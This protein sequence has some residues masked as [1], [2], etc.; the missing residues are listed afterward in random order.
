MRLLGW[1]PNTNHLL[2]G[3]SL[4]ENI[5]FVVG[6]GGKSKRSESK[7]FKTLTWTDRGMLWQR[8]EVGLGKWQSYGTQLWIC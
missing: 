5:L 6:T 1:I 2:I 8:S 4:K 7:E 3:H